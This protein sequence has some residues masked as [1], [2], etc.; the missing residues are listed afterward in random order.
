M[1]FS[2]FN[3]GFRIKHVQQFLL[4]NS[5]IEIGDEF[6][7]HSTIVYFILYKKNIMHCISIIPYS[8]Y[9]YSSNSL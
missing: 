7:K 1:H 8:N 4:K 6:I 5:E 9:F 3:C 2:S